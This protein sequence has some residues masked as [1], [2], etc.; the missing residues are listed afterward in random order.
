MKPPFQRGN[1]LNNDDVS[2]T[3]ED[4]IGK[5][6]RAAGQ[7]ESMPEELKQSWS[8][9]FREELA[10]T[11]NSHQ[12]RRNNWLAACASVLLVGLIALLVLPGQKTEPA[13][14][15]NAFSGNS[16]ITQGNG[17]PL[18]LQRGQLL[19][20]GNLIATQGQSFLSIN[21]R[22]FDVRLNAQ[23]RLR[24]DPDRLTL[25][26][27]EIYVS[28]TDSQ[29]DQSIAIATPFA[30]IRDVGTQFIVN[31]TDSQV[32]STVRQG[33]ILVETKGS[34]TAATATAFHAQRVTVDQQNHI[35]ITE[36]EGSGEHWEWIYQLTPTF[37]L[38]GKTV[39]EFLLWATRE[40]G[41]ALQFI[42]QRAEL[43]ARTTLLRGDIPELNPATSVPMVLATTDL[44]AIA[45]QPGTLRVS[46]SQP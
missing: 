41:Q 43:Y 37:R 16:H 45:E 17:K 46:L 19:S 33:S 40:T 5:I 24:I 27:G 35:D 34:K 26:S 11:R 18:Q 20:T 4:D 42:D 39:Y 25:L 23:T 28:S 1:T 44:K 30:T 12:K 10:T 22:S 6:L 29:L 8:N 9:H 3:D 21:Y 14:S 32:V 15:V 31:L 7:R 38:E 36:T 13:I 2:A